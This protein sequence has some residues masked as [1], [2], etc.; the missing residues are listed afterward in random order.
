MIKTRITTL[1]AGC[2]IITCAGLAI[3]TPPKAPAKA[4]SGTNT[5]FFE[6]K[7]RPILTKECLP[8]HSRK[9]GSVQGGLSMDTR[10]DLLTGSSKG[11]LIVPGKPKDSLLMHVVRH[12]HPTI[13]MPPGKKL[14]DVQLQALELWISNGAVDP[15]GAQ[16]VVVTP[17]TR[18]QKE[19][20]YRKPIAPPVPTETNGGWASLPIDHFVAVAQKRHGLKAAPTASGKL[21]LR[22]IAM[23]LTGIMPTASE[24]DAFPDKPTQADIRKAIDAYLASHEYGRRWGRHWLDIARYAE[25]SG[26][27]A[28]IAYPEAWLALPRLRHR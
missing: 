8:C 16:Q 27:D 9:S 10:M 24:L 22:R 28:N 1:I 4:T 13:K 7:I 11:P 26:K 21:L 25:S 20:A 15:R 5:A 3:Q 2:S 12:V 18:E 23:D 6:A 17:E 14:T 19:W